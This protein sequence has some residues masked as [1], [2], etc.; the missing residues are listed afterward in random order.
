MIPLSILV[1][2]GLFGCLAYYSFHHRFSRW[3]ALL[4]TIQVVFVS[5]EFWEIPIFVSGFLGLAYWWPYPSLAFILHHIYVCIIFASLVYIHRL[6]K[7]IR[8][9]SWLL[10]GIILNW[11]L[12]IPSVSSEGVMWMTRAFGFF[13]LWSGVYDGSTLVDV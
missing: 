5:S 8:F 11:M 7:N 3:I 4:T 6:T 2:Y 13:I 1:F 9:Y 12:L 10:L